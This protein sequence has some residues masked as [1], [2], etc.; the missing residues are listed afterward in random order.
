MSERAQ[1]LRELFE[2][3]REVGYQSHFRPEFFNDPAS[4]REWPDPRERERRL[5]SRW[6]EVSE[7]HFAKFCAE[8]AGMT[9]AQLSAQVKLVKS[10]LVTDRYSELLER[11][12]AR[13][14]ANDNDRGF[15][16]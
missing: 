14:P 3:W 12:A 6:K 5:W 7:E 11:Q 15:S 2:V 16:R 4:I 8:K 1:V 9:A 13:V 10:T